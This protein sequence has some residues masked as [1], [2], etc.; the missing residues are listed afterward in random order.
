VSGA[1]RST[2]TQRQDCI[3]R[4]SGAERGNRRGL[5]LKTARHCVM[6]AIRISRQTRNCTGNGFLKDLE[7][8]GITL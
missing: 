6:A 8:E 4:I 3:T 2:G 1:G 7:G 5:T